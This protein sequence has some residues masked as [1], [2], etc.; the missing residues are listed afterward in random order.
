MSEINTLLVLLLLPF[1]FEI[2]FH[3]TA[4]FFL[5]QQKESRVQ[6]PSC[7]SHDPTANLSDLQ[8]TLC[9]PLLENAIW[10]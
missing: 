9:F 8:L 4:V 6:L 1:V 10:R 3:Q 5:S 2:P 7:S